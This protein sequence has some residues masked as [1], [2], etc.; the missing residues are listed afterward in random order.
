MHPLLVTFQASMQRGLA[1]V[2]TRLARC[3]AIHGEL[4]L[5]GAFAAVRR[6]PSNGENV[7]IA[8]GDALAGK[9]CQQ[10]LC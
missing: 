4:R 2:R 5:R 9:H 1:Q 6:T 3:G 10:N 8:V 7:A